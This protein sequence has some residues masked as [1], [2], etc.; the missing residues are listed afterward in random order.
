MQN[1]FVIKPGLIISLV[2]L[3]MIADR[4][5]QF[6]NEAIPVITVAFGAEAQCVIREVNL[7]GPMRR[8]HIRAA[9]TALDLLR[10]LLLKD[11]DKT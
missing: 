4:L 9:A 10:E 2:Q 11:D 5:E 3:W 1:C 6:D 7:Q 8:R